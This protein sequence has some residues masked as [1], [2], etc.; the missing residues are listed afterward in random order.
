MKRRF[1]FTKLKHCLKNAVAFEKRIPAFFVLY[2]AKLSQLF[3]GFHAYIVR[4]EK[5][6]LPWAAFT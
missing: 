5:I 3:L 1:N 4:T 2:E 6:N